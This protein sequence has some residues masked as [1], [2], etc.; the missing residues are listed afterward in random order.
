MPITKTE[1]LGRDAAGRTDF[2]LPT[3]RA[4]Q[5]WD[6][7]LVESEVLSITTPVGY[8]RAFF[9]YGIGTNVW[10]TYDGS[11]PVIP[12]SSGASTQ[13]KEPAVRQIDPAGGQTLQFI[14]DSASYVNIRYDL[15]T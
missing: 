11:T 14:S 6:A 3:T 8:N 13:E 4:G 7:P 2:S 1:V 15:G 12:V 5:C 9:S 10:V